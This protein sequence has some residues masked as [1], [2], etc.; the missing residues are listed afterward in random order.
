[1]TWETRPMR[2]LLWAGLLATA[3]LIPAGPATAYDGP[4]C[5]R[6]NIGRGAVSEICHFPTFEACRSE[7]GLWGSTAFCSQNPRYL[8]YWKGRGFGPESGRTPMRKKKHRR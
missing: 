7:R 4:W 6:A 5:L 2:Q 1:M 8:P 3:A